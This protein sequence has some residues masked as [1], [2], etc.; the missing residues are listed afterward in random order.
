MIKTLCFHAKRQNTV[1]MQSFPGVLKKE[2]KS[3][4]L[5]PCSRVGRVT[6]NK[7][8]LF[9][10]CLVVVVRSCLLNKCLRGDGPAEF[11][12]KSKKN[13]SEDKVRTCGFQGRKNVFFAKSILTQS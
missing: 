7:H 4:G 10:P 13:A 5:G 9:R 8:F 1:K 6:V 12:W 3:L 11:V 2:E